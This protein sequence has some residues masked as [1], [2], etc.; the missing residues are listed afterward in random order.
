MWQVYWE[1]RVRPG[2]RLLE[3]ADRLIASLKSGQR[4]RLY[5][6]RPGRGRW[7]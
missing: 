4:R 6:G 7:V 2:E 5:P 1:P 3:E